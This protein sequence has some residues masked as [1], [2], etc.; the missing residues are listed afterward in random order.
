M[1]RRG[2]AVA[3]VG[4]VDALAQRPRAL[5]LLSLRGSGK[6][7]WGKDP[8]ATLSRGRSEWP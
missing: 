2:Q 5:S 4:P 3:V 1:T 8:A 6:G 7:L